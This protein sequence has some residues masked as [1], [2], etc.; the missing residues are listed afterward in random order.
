MYNATFV[1]FNYKQPNFLFL[2]RIINELANHVKIMTTFFIYM[3]SFNEELSCQSEKCNDLQMSNF[4]RYMKLPAYCC[5]SSCLLLCNLHAAD[6]ELLYWK[7]MRV[8][9]KIL[10]MLSR[11]RLILWKHDHYSVLLNKLF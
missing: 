5:F 2:T 4:N 1:M 9:T 11:S 8:K 3:W 7:R 6:N 10:K